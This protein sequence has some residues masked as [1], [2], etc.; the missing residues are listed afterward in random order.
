MKKNLEKKSA[1]TLIE[2][3]AVVVIIGILA[4]VSV[5]ALSNFSNAAKEKVTEN[6]YKN[7]GTS[8]NSEFSKCLLN[9]SAVILNGHKCNNLKPPDTLAIEDFYNKNNIKNPYDSSKSVLGKD[10]CVAGTIV[11]KS[12]SVG[13]YNISY[14]NKSNQT[15]T[16]NINSTWSV[17]NTNASNVWTPI[18]TGASNCWVPI[19]TG[20]T[21]VWTTVVTG[22]N[23]I[24]TA[25]RP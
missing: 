6:V 19:N 21:N 24:W 14:V 7:I 3:L 10:S 11:I 5:V 18:N 8:L 12:P 2:I 15:I 1:F 22:A 20:A 4:T 13:N 17:V 9:K 25:I 16:A 23:N